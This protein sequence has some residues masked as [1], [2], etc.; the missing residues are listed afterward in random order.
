MALKYAAGTMLLIAAAGCGGAPESL[1]RISVVLDPADRRFGAVEI[2][3]APPGASLSVRL[4]RG[5]ASD[6][7]PLFGSVAG[8]GA[9]LQFTPHYRPVGPGVYEVRLSRPGSTPMLGRFELGAEPIPA[10]TTR[11]VGVYPG[12]DRIPENLL[13]WYLE[14]SAPMSEGEAYRRVRLLDAEGRE[15]PKA[16]L[17]V[18]EELWNGDRRRLTLLFD[19]GRLKRG[20]KSNLDMGAP[21]VA[22]H[23]YVLV[24][25]GEWRDGRGA[26]LVAGYRRDFVAIPADRSRPDP[27]RW[28]VTPPQAGTRGALTVNFGESLDHVLASELIAVVDRSG[29]PV[30]GTGRVMARETGWR[31]E[32]AREWTAAT[33]TLLIAPALED[34]A[35]NNLRGVFDRDR[36]A[37][38]TLRQTRS[39]P[40]RL[41]FTPRPAVD[42][43]AIAID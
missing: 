41:Q 18:D 4:L 42:S 30:R 22:G 15:V 2:S 39:G 7:P 6:G 11:I 1:P 43:A 28:R 36:E 34:L 20:I 40:T 32:P 31:F 8:E 23:R 19:P 12:G 3:D 38:D 10:A 25:D 21:L 33:H 26:P 24:I 5:N 35:G 37:G 29:H 13:K 14:F 17:V 9:R 16:F 27:T